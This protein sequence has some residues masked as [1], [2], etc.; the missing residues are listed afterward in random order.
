MKIVSLVNQSLFPFAKSEPAVTL[1]SGCHFVDHY[2]IIT[3]DIDHTSSSSSS[4]PKNMK[5]AAERYISHVNLMQKHGTFYFANKH[6]QRIGD[7]Y[8]ADASLEWGEPLL[9]ISD[10]LFPQD[11]YLDVLAKCEMAMNEMNIEVIL[12]ANQLSPSGNTF[13]SHGLTFAFAEYSTTHPEVRQAN[14]CP[15]YMISSKATY[16]IAARMDYQFFNG[17]PYDMM[18]ATNFRSVILKNT[19]FYPYETSHKTPHKTEIAS[20]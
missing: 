14:V 3:E 15:A 17:L 16:L 9:V 8:C 10:R 2:G 19:P 11:N 1:P 5:A 12:L 18:L 7:G 13:T 20:I 6:G 4:T